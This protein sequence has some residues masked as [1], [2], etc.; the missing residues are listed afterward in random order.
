MWMVCN[1]S[2]ALGEYTERA[3]RNFDKSRFL[4]QVSQLKINM[5]IFATMLCSPLIYF[6]VTSYFDN[7][8]NQRGT[9]S[10]SGALSD[11]RKVSRER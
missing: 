2:G 3:L 4:T 7:R 5:L 10:F 1:E 9:L 6:T 11:L 8:G